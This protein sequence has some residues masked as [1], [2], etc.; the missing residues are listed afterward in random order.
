MGVR[1]ISLRPEQQ[2]AVPFCVKCKKAPC[3]SRDADD[4]IAAAGRLA[5][6]H[7]PDVLL[8]E[9]VGSCTDLVATVINPLKKLYADRFSV[10]PYVA[11]LDPERAY[12]ALSGNATGGFSAKVTYI[13][14]MQQ[15]EADVVAILEGKLTQSRYNSDLASRKVLS[16]QAS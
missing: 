7:K 5:D 12:H 4:L 15:N 2:I 11:L 14:K 1:N 9:P 16:N 10:A 3:L 8:A 13:Y 6:G